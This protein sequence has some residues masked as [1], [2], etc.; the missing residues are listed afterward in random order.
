M[1]LLL[2]IFVAKYTG[3]GLVVKQP[4]VLSK[5]Q[6]LHLVLGVGVS[7]LLPIF[8]TQ[9]SKVCSV[10]HFLGLR[11]AEFSSNSAALLRRPVP[12]DVFCL[13][14]SMVWP[15]KNQNM[16]PEGPTIKKVQSR[17]KFSISIE[18]FNLAR[19]FQSRRLDFPIKNRAAVGGSLENL[20]LARNFQSRSKS[21]FSTH[22]RT[23]ARQHARTHFRTHLCRH[24]FWHAP[25]HIQDRKFESFAH[26]PGDPPILKIL[27]REKCGTDVGKCIGQGSIMPLLLGKEGTTVCTESDNTTAVARYCGFGASGIPTSGTQTLKVGLAMSTHALG[28]SGGFWKKSYVNFF[29]FS[30]AILWETFKGQN[31]SPNG[32]D[33]IFKRSQRASE[34]LAGP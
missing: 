22:A 30:A 25:V 20:I 26:N 13:E 7:S 12:H 2:D 3:R 33:C 24:A 31:P 9:S 15:Q 14:K 16:H 8:W 32:Q 27:R 10:L 29:G 5:V 11:V 1:A 28:P 18:I 4:G 23:H 19:K 17:S 34:G 6:M 21:R